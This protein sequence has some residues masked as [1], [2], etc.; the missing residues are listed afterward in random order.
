MNL[1]LLDNYDSF[2]YNLHHLL[3]QFHNV[4]VSVL[5]ND[6]IDEEEAGRYDRIVLSPGPGLPGESGSMMSIIKRY[7]FEKPMLGVCLGMQAIA[8]VCGGK[9]INLEHPLHG[10]SRLVKV[11][12][13]EEKLFQTLPPVFQTGRY[14]SW[15]VSSSDLPHDLS[16]TATDEENNVMAITHANGFLRGI[17]FHPESILTEFGKIIIS[18]WLY[19][20]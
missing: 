11:V 1:L 4:H 10:E 17:Q 18:N 15:C 20:C 6:E 8:Q 14:H 13:K 12:D 2:T 5:R 3:A 7:G 16:I 9:L 19:E